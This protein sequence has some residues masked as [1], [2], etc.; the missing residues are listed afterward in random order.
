MLYIAFLK[1][2]NVGSKNRINMKELK[3]KLIDQGFKQVTTYINSG[4]I[5]L[6]SELEIDKINECISKLIFKQF[7]L[8]IPVVTRKKEEFDFLINNKPYSNKQIA[9][10]G[11]DK[12]Y[13]CF[14]VAFLSLIPSKEEIDKFSKYKSEVEDFSIYNNNIFLLLSC[15]I[16]ES[17][18][19]RQL[20]KLD[21]N[22][23]VRNWNTILK[24]KNISDQMVL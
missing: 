11:R 17:K 6:E 21:K 18:L 16:R 22:A 12:S 19:S 9:E 10:I 7:N 4:N 13:E 1:G 3:S 8:E 14:Y 24:L 2:I 15:S 5:V 23:T 20:I